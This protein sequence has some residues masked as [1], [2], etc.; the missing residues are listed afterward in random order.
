MQAIGDESVVFVPGNEGGGYKAVPVTLGDEAK[1]WIENKLGNSAN[2]DVVSV[3]A[4]DLMLVI[5]NI[6]RIASGANSCPPSGKPLPDSF[7]TAP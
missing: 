6:G 7:D 2:T 1:G 5:T 3:G 4:L